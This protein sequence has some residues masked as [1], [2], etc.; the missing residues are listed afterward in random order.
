MRHQRLSLSV[1]GVSTEARHANALPSLDRQATR[2]TMEMDASQIV[3][4]CS[5]GVCR[6]L[7]LSDATCLAN[8][9]DLAFVDGSMNTDFCGTLAELFHA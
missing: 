7:A 8:L 1:D 3:H 5:A 9:I 6:V 2:V 4:R